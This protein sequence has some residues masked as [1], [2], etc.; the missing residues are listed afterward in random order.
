MNEF[1]TVIIMDESQKEDIMKK[2]NTITADMI[3][4]VF[5]QDNKYLF[6]SQRHICKRSTSD[7]DKLNKILSKP[8]EYATETLI[9]SKI[10]LFSFEPEMFI[11][12]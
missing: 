6:I 7:T 9:V 3:K 1:V 4:Q 12:L 5:N 2:Y 8:V 10:Y 11:S